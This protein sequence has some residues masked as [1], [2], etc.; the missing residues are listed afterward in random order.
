MHLL[1]V[2]TICANISLMGALVYTKS[3]Q[4]FPFFFIAQAVC[5]VLTVLLLWAYYS[6]LVDPQSYIETW[7]LTDEAFVLINAV[8]GWDLMSGCRNNRAAWTLASLLLIQCALT[9]ICYLDDATRMHYPAWSPY[10]NLALTVGLIW[11]VYSEGK[12]VKT[13]SEPQKPHPTTPPV[14]DPKPIHPT[15][16]V[17][18]GAPDSK[19]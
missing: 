11:F 10:F 4:R 8:I 15:P 1:W 12:E 14:E 19:G 16:D 17:Q 18:P 5:V 3:R 13:M 6:P 9:L 2:F 7:T